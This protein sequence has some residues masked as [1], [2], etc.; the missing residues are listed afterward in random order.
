MIILLM[1]VVGTIFIIYVWFNG[2]KLIRIV[3]N[4][5]ESLRNIMMML[6]LSKRSNISRM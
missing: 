2:R 5:G 1:L 3:R 4:V 6:L